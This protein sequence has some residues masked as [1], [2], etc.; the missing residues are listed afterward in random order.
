MTTPDPKPKPN[1]RDFLFSAI[2]AG[3]LGC[4]GCPT[5]L[6]LSVGGDTSPQSFQERSSQNSGMTFEDVY[7]FAFRDGFIPLAKKMAEAMG[8]AEFTELLQ[9]AGLERGR[10]AGSAFAA[11]LPDNEF[12][13]FAGTMRNPP[14]L[15]GGALTF[16]MIEDLQGI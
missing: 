9:E 2:P 6:G 11:S 10:E 5:V 15:Y 7:N 14:P 8:E 13:T 4:L 12:S 1:R 3:I 16:E